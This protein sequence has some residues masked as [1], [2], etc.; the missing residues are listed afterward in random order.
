MLTEQRRGHARTG[1][2]AAEV[3]CDDRK[4]VA[5]LWSEIAEIPLTDEDGTPTLPL[6]NSKLQNSRMAIR[7][8]VK[9]AKLDIRIDTFAI[10]ATA[11]SEP[12]VVVEMARVIAA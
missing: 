4:H 11:L 12:I 5:T 7:Q 10:G 8:A 6:D 3:Q 1:I 9:A 2:V